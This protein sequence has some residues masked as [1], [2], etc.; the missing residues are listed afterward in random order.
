MSG[1][2]FNPVKPAIP[3]LVAGNMLFKMFLYLN[4]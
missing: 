1:S 2:H 4:E 3:V